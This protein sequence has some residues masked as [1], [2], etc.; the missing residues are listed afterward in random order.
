M[1][2]DT[3]QFN[4]SNLLLIK[5][6]DALDFYFISK[7]KFFFCNS[8]FPTL[9]FLI[10]QHNGHLLLRSSSSSVCSEHE[11]PTASRWAWRATGAQTGVLRDTMA[12]PKCWGIKLQKLRLCLLCHMFYLFRSLIFLTKGCFWKCHRDGLA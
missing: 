11:H 6:L 12:K 5:N 7:A 1:G 4:V 8:K 10:I 2:A 3:L 9:P